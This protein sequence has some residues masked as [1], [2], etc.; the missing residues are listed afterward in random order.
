[1]CSRQVSPAAAVSQFGSVA[2][3]RYCA[4]PWQK[5]ASSCEDPPFTSANLHLSPGCVIRYGIAPNSTMGFDSTSWPLDSENDGPWRKRKT[6][7]LIAMIATVTTGNRSLGML[8]RSGIK[9]P[10]R[11]S[12]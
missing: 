5:M 7:K 9:G 3:S 8:S 10:E 11:V 6:K 12:G 1:M 4:E 2:I